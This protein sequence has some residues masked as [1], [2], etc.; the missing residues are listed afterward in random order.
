MQKIANKYYR[1]QGSKNHVLERDDYVHSA[2]FY[3]L[4]AIEKYDPSRGVPEGAY[5]TQWIKSS[6]SNMYRKYS[7]VESIDTLSEEGFQV[8]ASYFTPFAI[9]SEE[10]KY[11]YDVLDMLPEHQKTLLTI[12]Y[13]LNGVKRVKIKDYA[14]QQGLSRDQVNRLKKKALIQMRK[15][16]TNHEEHNKINTLFINEDVPIKSNKILF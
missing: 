15:L 14:V 3:V 10:K 8:T 6:C 1:R 16:Y 2:V 4:K 12:L 13:G 9:S 7:S 5:V 11:M